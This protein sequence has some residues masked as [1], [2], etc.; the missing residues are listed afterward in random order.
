VY[1]RD[2][3]AAVSTPPGAGGIG[4]V[5]LSGVGALEILARLFV[6]QRERTP[7]PS[8]R[9][10]RGRVVDASG[11]AIDEVLAVAMR[12]PHSYTGEDVVEIHCHGSPPVLRRVL[13]RCCECGART[14]EPGEFTKRAFLNGRIDLVQAEAVAA[15]IGART[16]SASRAAL[17]Q[18]GGRLSDELG[19]LRERL[20]DVRAR[21]EIMLDFSEEEI[22]LTPATVADDIGAVA[23][24]IGRLL[25]SFEGGRLLREGVRLAI[26]GRPNVGKSSL[27]N[28]LLGVE[29]AIV[30]PAP[31]TT[32]DVVSDDLEIDGIPVVLA[33]T[34]GL[35]ASA[36]PVEQLGIERA[37]LEAARAD[38]VLIVL[39]GSQPL[40][41][42]DRAALAEVGGTP[43]IRVVNKSDL[44][45]AWSPGGED[46]PAPVVR[47]SAL[48]GAG[49]AELRR[50]IVQ[51]VGAGD[52]DPRA[53]IVTAVRQRDALAR[54]REALDR[55][56]AALR[57]AST[58]DAAAVDIQ[59]AV[60]HIGAITGEVTTEDIL[61]RIF[62]DFCIGK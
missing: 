51:L 34:A 40:G 59:A 11:E 62:R 43:S 61:D 46:V 22:D 38:A 7:P 47:V 19:E 17:R 14:A 55:A 24:R 25:A 37:R 57:G 5:R 32:R 39:D 49:L 10:V 58:I 41:E 2:T 23:A 31:G 45:S 50:A 18:L 1:E 20:I 42:D 3:I 48:T 33:D 44:P 27:L 30:T 53:P 9:L 12:G 8:H 56:L 28:A 60:E 29:R 54:A 13:A 52:L 6:P 21:I 15:L 35:R 26:V 36:D 4:V 16:E